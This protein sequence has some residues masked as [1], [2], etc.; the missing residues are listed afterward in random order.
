MVLGSKPE[1][2][3]VKFTDAPV[4]S[5]VLLSLMVGFWLLLQQTPRAVT[6][7]PPSS[8]ICPPDVAVVWVISVISAVDRIGILLLLSSFLQLLKSINVAPTRAKA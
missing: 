7:A 8:V 6:L 4:P 3:L 5:S 1:M 2:L